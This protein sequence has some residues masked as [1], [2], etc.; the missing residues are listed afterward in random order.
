MRSSKP[1]RA[2]IPVMIMND[3][4]YPQIRVKLPTPTPLLLW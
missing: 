4:K 1:P 2:Q 3:I